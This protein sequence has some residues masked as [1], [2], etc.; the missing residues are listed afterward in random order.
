MAQKQ[1]QWRADDMRQAGINPLLAS[2]MSATAPSS[3]KMAEFDPKGI[4]SALA[5]AQIKKTNAET[6][7]TRTNTDRT[8]VEID[9]WEPFGAIGRGASKILNFYNNMKPYAQPGTG[10]VPDST[11]NKKTGH[12]ETPGITLEPET[13]KEHA[14]H[15]RKL[16][17]RGN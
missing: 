2:G 6:A 1:V 3:Q 8:Q 7:N 5:L 9:R 4:Q 17:N 16:K 10:R 13:A 15:M 12:W 14:E 11:F